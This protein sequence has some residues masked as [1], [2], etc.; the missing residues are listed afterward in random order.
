MGRP[1][2]E[3]VNHLSY[4]ENFL[5]MLDHL[6]VRDTATRPIQQGMPRRRSGGLTSFI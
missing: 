4:V 2:N 6:Q 3:P 1:Y 5:Y